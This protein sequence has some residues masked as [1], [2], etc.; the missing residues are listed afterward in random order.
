VA[1]RDPGRNEEAA[2]ARGGSAAWIF[3]SAEPVPPSRHGSAQP[4]QRITVRDPEL[5]AE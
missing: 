1:Y 2:A 4:P 5:E 3:I